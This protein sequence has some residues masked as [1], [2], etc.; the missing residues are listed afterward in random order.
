MSENGKNVKDSF[1]KN[2][3]KSFTFFFFF[4][5]IT[6]PDQFIMNS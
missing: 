5:W 2:L 6:Q 3:E 1:S 4:T